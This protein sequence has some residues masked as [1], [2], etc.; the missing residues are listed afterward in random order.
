MTRIL[1]ERNPAVPP[2]ACRRPCPPE[3]DGQ[4][5]NIPR[6]R[7][8]S[9]REACELKLLRSRMIDFEDREILRPRGLAVAERVQP[10]SQYDVLTNSM[11]KGCLQRILGKS[12]P[13]HEVRAQMP[14]R[15]LLMRCKFNL[16]GLLAAH[17]DQDDGEWIGK[18]LRIIIDQLVDCP[19]GGDPDRSFTAARVLHGGHSGLMFA[20]L[21]TGAHF[22][23]SAFCRVPSASGVSCSRDGS[24]WP[25]SASRW[26]T[27]RAVSALTTAEFSFATISPGVPLGTHRPCQKG[28]CRPG[29]PASSIV[30]TSGALAH[31]VFDITA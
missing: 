24:S 31:R 22:S 25:S 18:N 2:Q 3:V 7:D 4:E 23:I 20:A 17:P 27:S 14:L 9:P 15:R 10:G 26:L 8:P 28:M 16:Q 13:Q 6:D 12:A 11:V 30:G 21:M 19:H 1:G 29:T 5:A